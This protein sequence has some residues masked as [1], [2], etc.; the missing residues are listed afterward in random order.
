MR[1]K[2]LKATQ[3]IVFLLE[4]PGRTKTAF[5]T[6]WLPMILGI[7]PKSLITVC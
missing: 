3:S 7:N 1:R 6:H 5:L 4:L 2:M